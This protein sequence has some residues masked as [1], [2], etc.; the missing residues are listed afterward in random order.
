MEITN[1]MMAEVQGWT[2]H[3][4]NGNIIGWYDKSDSFVGNPDFIHDLNLVH[5]IEA[6]LTDEEWIEYIHKLCRQISRPEHRELYRVEWDRE[7]VNATALQKC[8]A[9][10]TILLKRKEQG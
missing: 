2:S 9:L 7:L 1:S 3:T 5:G 10:Y 8:T 4:M 6:G